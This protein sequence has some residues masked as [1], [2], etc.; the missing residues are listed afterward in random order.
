MVAQTQEED[1]KQEDNKLVNR[2]SIDI[3]EFAIKT[4]PGICIIGLLGAT[5]GALGL[6]IGVVVGA[7][8]G[9]YLTYRELRRNGRL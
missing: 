9:C 5:Y 8:S 1:N 6:I 2:K 3:K 4:I 7:I